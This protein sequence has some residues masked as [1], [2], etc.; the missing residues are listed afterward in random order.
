MSVNKSNWIKKCRSPWLLLLTMFIT[1][2]PLQAIAAQA[3]ATVSKN[4][5]AVNQVFRL[6]ISVDTAINP[7]SIDFSVLSPNFAYG[8]PNA[9]SSTSFI[10][11]ALSRNTTW[12]LSL[13]AKKVGAATIPAFKI[14]SSQT[15]PITITVLKGS[16]TNNSATDQANVRV[17][18]E[19]DKNILYVGE[20][21]N[22]R[23]KI[24]IGEQLS[25][26]SLSAPSGDG[27]AVSQV[28]QDAQH[29]IVQNGRRY[30]VITRNYQL[31]AEKAGKIIIQGS[32]FNGNAVRGANGFNSGITV[33]VN[34]DARN[35]TI[36]IKPKPIDY[37]GLWLPTPDLQLQ[38]TWQPQVSNLNDV[39]TKVG[40]PITRTITLRIKDV[41]QSN[42]PNV[43]LTYPDTVRIYNEKPEYRTENGYS[44]MTLK[45]V[46]IPR[47]TGKVTLPPLTINWW[48]TT[49]EKQQRSKIKGLTLNVIAD[50]TANNQ[51]SSP[52]TITPPA[53]TI[54]SA[55]TI[56]AAGIWPWTTLVFALLWL[57]T[58][59]LLIKKRQQTVITTTVTATQTTDIT[60]MLEAAINA[61]EPIKV[62]TYYQQWRQQ[63]YSTL[64]TQP[65]LL[66]QLDNE[67]QAMMATHYSPLD[68]VWNNQTL[69]ALLTQVKQLTATKKAP[70]TLSSL[71]PQ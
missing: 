44:V 38:Q 67:V 22:Y 29:N 9:S 37:K 42:M 21:I 18:A 65:Q 4:V 5:V 6:S 53:A 26:A 28:G 27:L 10:N 8:Q 13:A 58:L 36:N 39:T 12:T 35:I 25:Q 1:L 59:V 64:T 2:L 61:N 30:L 56:T 62:Q 14:G 51:F 63:Q 16:Q 3:E 60:S 41:A 15:T 24:L 50:P 70:M 33:P 34:E 66:Q 47:Q 52:A 54:H 69:L 19:I 11:G 45:Q 17:T 48:N 46:I 57:I 49:T 55:K 68:S 32:K 71:D 43:N 40:E 20:S 23:V 7:D 31:T